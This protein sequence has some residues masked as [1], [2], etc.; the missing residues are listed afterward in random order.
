[1][2]RTDNTKHW[3]E[4]GLEVTREI[5]RRHILKL[6][7]NKTCVII[8]STSICFALRIVNTNQHDISKYNQRNNTLVLC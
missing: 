6:H 3:R 8:P 2:G 5:A 1:M 7:K 4:G